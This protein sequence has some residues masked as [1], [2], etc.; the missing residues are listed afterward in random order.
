MGSPVGDSCFVNVIGVF[1]YWEADPIDSGKALC[2]DKTNL[3]SLLE[4]ERRCSEVQ[5]D[6][7][8][9]RTSHLRNACQVFLARY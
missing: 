8:G 7:Q 2:Q 9:P 6:F 4:G 3:S 5:R 1:G